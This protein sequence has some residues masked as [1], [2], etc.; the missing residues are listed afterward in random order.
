ME[1]LQKKCSKLCFNSDPFRKPKNSILSVA[2][3]LNASISS[4][5][6]AIFNLTLGNL[7]NA[8]TNVFNL[9]TFDNLPE[10]K[11]NLLFYYSQL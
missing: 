2:N 11:K 6:P 7:E 1:L 9:F 5:V 8:C 10:Y 4:P 3:S